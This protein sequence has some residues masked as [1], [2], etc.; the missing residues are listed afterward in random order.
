MIQN[1]KVPFLNQYLLKKLTMEKI[2]I[3]ITEDH[4]LLRESCVMV[5][6]S[7]PR[8]TVVAQCRSGE[9]AVD[10]ARDLRPNVVIMDI[11]LP[12]M[13]GFET[14][15][16]IRKYSPG[17]RIL[18][19]S[20]HTQPAYVRQ[21]MRLGATGY[22]TKNSPKEELFEAIIAIHDNRKYICAEIK[23]ILSEQALHSDEKPAGIH[24]LSKR[25]L[26]IINYLK[27]GFSS[28]EIADTA[29]ISRKTVE[30]HRYN[31]LKKLNLPNVASLVN[32]INHNQF[33]ME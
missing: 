8:F 6:N 5:L 14:T 10:L 2:T 4:T 29:S 24:S 28:K 16:Q 22:V 30:V 25:E 27:K 21:I 17:S 32:F 15:K 23:N 3:L 7:D 11:N 26:D 20:L 19:L 1:K 13:N 33:A 12:G 18:C 31:I 9:E